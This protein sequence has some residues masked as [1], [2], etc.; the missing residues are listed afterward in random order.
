MKYTELYFEIQII[1]FILV[2][3]FILFFCLLYVFKQIKWKLKHKKRVD[4]E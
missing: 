3:I 4:K 2:C 1:G